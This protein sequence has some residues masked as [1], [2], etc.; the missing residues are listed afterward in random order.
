MNL[1]QQISHK[2]TQHL[3]AAEAANGALARRAHQIAAQCYLR[4]LGSGPEAPP[5]PET[6]RAR[7]TAQAHAAVI[8][9]GLH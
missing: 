7:S 2:A 8:L 6:A 9:N 4:Q 5:D 1:Q 3:Q